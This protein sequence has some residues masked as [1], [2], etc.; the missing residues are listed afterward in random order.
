MNGWLLDTNVVSDLFKRRSDPRLA[1]WISDRPESD[2]YLSA[3]TFAEIGKGVVKLEASGDPY[4]QEVERN[5]AI[6]RARYADR[7]LP[8]DEA[9]LANWA[10]IMGRAAAARMTLDSIDQIFSATAI[11]HGLILATRNL[12]DFPEI[13]GVSVVDPWAD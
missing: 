2:L 11:A 9:V 8:V 5:A 10:R 12:K 6:L 13:V 7:I 4:A 1:K 3:F